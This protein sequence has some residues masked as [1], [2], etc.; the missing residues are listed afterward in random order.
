MTPFSSWKHLNNAAGHS[1]SFPDVIITRDPVT[2]IQAPLHLH[3]SPHATATIAF[4]PLRLCLPAVIDFR[5]EER[6]WRGWE[7]QALHANSSVCKNKTDSTQTLFAAE[8]EGDLISSTHAA[9]NGSRGRCR[10]SEPAQTPARIGRP[11]SVAPRQSP[12]VI[13]VDVTKC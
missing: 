3:P 6:Y 2:Q 8:G 1:V 13:R 5:L 11:A 4:L 12:R 7:G 9:H 10:C